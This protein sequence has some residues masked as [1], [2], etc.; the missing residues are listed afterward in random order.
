MKIRRIIYVTN[1]IIRYQDTSPNELFLYCIH[2]RLMLRYVCLNPG[3]Q[4]LHHCHEKW[5][6]ADKCKRGYSVLL[7]LDQHDTTTRAIILFNIQRSTFSSSKSFLELRYA[8]TSFL[9]Y[10]CYQY[11]LLLWLR[12]NVILYLE[13]DTI[14]AFPFNP[15]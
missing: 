9:A 12:I 13:W 11:G 7:K 3:Q 1:Y 4:R 10:N 15:Q 6:Y 14:I 2:K 8:Q 5:W